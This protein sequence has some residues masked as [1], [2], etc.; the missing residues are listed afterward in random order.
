MEHPMTQPD[1]LVEVMAEIKSLQLTVA[2]L[3]AIVGER[4]EC[5]AKFESFVRVAQ[6]QQTGEEHN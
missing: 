3:E 1:Q 4:T 6:K 5:G 2:A